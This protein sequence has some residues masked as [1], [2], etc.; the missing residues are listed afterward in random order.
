[1]GHLL[2]GPAEPRGARLLLRHHQGTAFGEPPHGR[3]LVRTPGRRRIPARRRQR[4]ERLGEEPP[5]RSHRRPTTRRPGPDLPWTDR[6][7][8]GGGRPGPAVAPGEVRASRR[9]R[10]V[11]VGRDRS[12]GRDRSAARLTTTGSRRTR[13]RTG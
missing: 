5:R 1:G 11:G 2:G 12:T 13:S 7:R 8:S 4:G 10:P 9:R 3:D 6:G